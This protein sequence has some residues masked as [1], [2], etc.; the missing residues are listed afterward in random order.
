MRLPVLIAIGISLAATLWILSGVFFGGDEPPPAEQ[1]GQTSPAQESQAEKIAEVRVRTMRAEPMQDDIRVTGKTLASRKLDIRAETDGQIVKLLAQEGDKV[2]EGQEIAKIELG[3]RQARV[4]EASQLVAQREIQHRAA[5]ELAEKGFNSRVRLAEARAQLEAARAQLKQ[6][7]F[8]LGKTV[9]KAPF[10]GVISRQHVEVGD[11]VSKGNEIFSFVDLDPV[12]IEGFL[13]EGQVVAVNA[14]SPA[15]ASILNG[16]TVEGT[17]KY[18]APAADP[19]TRTFRTLIAAANPDHSIKEGLTADMII[20]LEEKQAYK[21]SPSIL[22]LT[23][24]GTVGVK[25][26]DDNNQVQF[27]A[28]QMLRDTPEYLWIGGLPEEVRMITVG[29]EFVLPGQTVKPVDAD[30][31]GL[32]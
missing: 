10:D 30:G 29:Q 12:E 7:R 23:D 13:T 1:A 21:I 2:A 11:Y 22:S 5:E 9:I 16:Q 24:D 31:D 25:I 19:E 3:D 4:E 28:V 15:R 27:I 6:V 20:P 18:V 8:D 26:V 32:L 17:I 14:G